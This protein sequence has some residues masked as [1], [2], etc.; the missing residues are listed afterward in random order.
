MRICHQTVIVSS[1]GAKKLVRNTDQPEL[2]G[3]CTAAA[4]PV[5][6]ALIEHNALH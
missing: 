5:A 4:F 3:G 1:E 6:R 2:E